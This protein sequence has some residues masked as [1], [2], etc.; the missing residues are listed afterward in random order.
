MTADLGR[1][2]RIGSRELVPAGG[3]HQRGA[4]NKAGTEGKVNPGKAKTTLYIK[5]LC[6][7]E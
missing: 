2:S 7:K 1:P 4:P 6:V 5:K 3:A